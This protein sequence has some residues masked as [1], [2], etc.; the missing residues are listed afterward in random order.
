M[1]ESEIRFGLVCVP[2]QFFHT[3]SISDRNKCTRARTFLSN[4]HAD[5]FTTAEMIIREQLSR[6]II[7]AAKPQCMTASLTSGKA[8]TS[9]HGTFSSTQEMR[10]ALE[11]REQSESNGY[12]YIANTIVRLTSDVN[13]CK[14]IRPLDGLNSITISYN[15]A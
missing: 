6:C 14:F 15:I 3:S 2:M 5:D 7:E 4:M 1:A 13:Y 8:F 11:T 9:N 10:L 12:Y